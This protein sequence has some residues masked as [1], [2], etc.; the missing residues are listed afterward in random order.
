MNNN[1]LKNMICIFYFSLFLYTDTEKT[2]D[3]EWIIASLEIKKLF[4]MLF[5]DDKGGDYYDKA[6]YLL[7][8]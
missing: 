5:D 4:F 3:S 7:K 6:L 8:N 2:N 1:K